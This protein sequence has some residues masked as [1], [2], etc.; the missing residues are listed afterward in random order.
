MINF[1]I[2]FICFLLIWIAIDIGR[3]N[4]SKIELFSKNWWI[5]FL[6][7]SLSGTLLIFIA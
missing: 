4:N 5:A 2:R 3:D 6:L 7:T 1:F